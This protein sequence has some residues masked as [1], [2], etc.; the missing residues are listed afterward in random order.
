MSRPNLTQVGQA[1]LATLRAGT[2]QGAPIRAA[3]TDGTELDPPAVIV[4]SPD[5]GFHTMGEGH[6]IDAT[7]WGLALHSSKGREPSVGVE[8]AFA[9]AVLAAL[10]ADPTLGGVVTMSN[11]VAGEPATAV[12]TGTLENGEPAP[13]TMYRRFIRFHVDH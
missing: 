11:P 2:F 7:E 6:I 13:P 10:A 3:L 12:S 1:L 8:L 5:I 9:D 4:T